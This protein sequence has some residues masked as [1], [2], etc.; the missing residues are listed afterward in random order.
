MAE[1]PIICSYEI[2]TIIPLFLDEKN[3]APRG[4]VIWQCKEARL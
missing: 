3:D 2:S 1:F 4:G